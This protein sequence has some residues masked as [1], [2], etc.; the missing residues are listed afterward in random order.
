M[1]S[2]RATQELYEVMKEFVPAE[3]LPA[4]VFALMTRV[5]GNRSFKDTMAEVLDLHT[6]HMN[7]L[8]KGQERLR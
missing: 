5:S 6:Q 7:E 1:L 8:A 4:L 3:R 2:K